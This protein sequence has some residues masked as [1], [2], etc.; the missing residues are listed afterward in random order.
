MVM[1]GSSTVDKSEVTSG[2]RS[3]ARAC[4]HS[5]RRSTC[6]AA[7]AARQHADCRQPWCTAG[8]T[9]VVPIENSVTLQPQE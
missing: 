5:A 3:H 6:R 9:T 2:P 4:H 8:A 7:R 1:V